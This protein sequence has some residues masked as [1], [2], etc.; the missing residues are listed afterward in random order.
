MIN[1]E[2]ATTMRSWLDLAVAAVGPEKLTSDA[3]A[4]SGDGPTVLIAIG[5]AATAM[6]LGAQRALGE[7]SG[8]CVTNTPGTVP[9]G[10]ELLIGDHPIPGDASFEAGRRVLEIARTARGRCVALISGGG[11]AL[12]EQPLPGVDRLYLQEVN[13]MLLDGGASIE[14]TNLVRQ[15]LSA[16]KC[17]G[18]ARAVS[19]HLETYLISDV[20]GAG[21]G[22]VASGPTIPT[23]R[24]PAEATVVMKRFDIP[25]PAAVR[26][27]INLPL[28]EPLSPSVEVLADG[29]TAAKAV[30]EAAQDEGL[31]SRLSEEWIESP[32]DTALSEFFAGSG[33]GV[34]VAAGEATVNVRGKGVGGRNSHAALLA[35]TRLRGDEGMF[36]SLATDGVDGRSDSAGAI[37]DGF[38]IERGGDPED[39]LAD[40]DSASYLD[41]T[42]DLIRMGPT[43]TNVADLWVL[44]RS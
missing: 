21:P 6:C 44:W 23:A 27:A 14:E 40:F 38:T 24:N 16:I 28:P 4:G 30:T 5:K 35:A 8:I 42:G 10:V 15:H 41:R 9:D 36:A 29:R 37:V 43:G 18:V 19:G 26:S 1:D 17:G 34:T 39:S 11:S 3:L 20:G 22:L 2:M 13:R 7:V 12:C 33:A 32:V 31:E 25:I